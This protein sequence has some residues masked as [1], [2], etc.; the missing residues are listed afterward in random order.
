M[1]DDGYDDDESG[2]AEQFF[3]EGAVH[4]RKGRAPS[5][6]SSQATRTRTPDRGAKNTGTPLSTPASDTWL[7]RTAGRFAVRRPSPARSRSPAQEASNLPHGN[8]RRYAS[9][10]L[11][12]G[13]M[14]R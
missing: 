2:E 1:G 4:G 10:H 11:R 9:D 14:G 7:N 13:T 12:L 8:H 5:S 3:A 6:S